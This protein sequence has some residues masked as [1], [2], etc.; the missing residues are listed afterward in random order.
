MAVLVGHR[1]TVSCIAFSPGGEKIATGSVD[2]TVR[3]W[4]VA[5]SW[6]AAVVEGHVEL[7][8][9]LTFSL[10]GS[11]VASGSYDN[12]ARTWN[13]ASGRE[14]AVMRGHSDALRALAFSS[15]GSKIASG[16]DDK[17]LRIWNT[18]RGLE[19]AVMRG[20]LDSVS[21]LAF[22]LDGSRIVSGSV[23]KTVRIWSTGDGRIVAV[24]EEYPMLGGLA[25]SPDGSKIVIGSWNKTVQ[26]IDAKTGQHIA[27]TSI[28]NPALH[29][30]FS[31]CNTQVQI[32]HQVLWEYMSNTLPV[33]L[34]SHLI[35]SYEVDEQRWLVNGG[36]NHGSSAS[37]I[38][39]I[40]DAFQTFNYIIASHN[41]LI[42]I[43]TDRGPGCLII[44]DISSI[45]P[46]T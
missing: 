16:S 41:S 25:I 23:D 21:C 3:I 20:H 32:N 4:N 5:N 9:C 34:P 1:D 28:G 30:S 19:M 39:R 29:L 2:S 22:S 17:T 42:A 14:V 18:A 31:S 33:S 10:D 37:R 44:L 8:T 11:Q 36:L 38:C 15:D 35:A 12:T 43:G 40:P 24:L 46:L 6:E 26:V 45:V 7:V 27:Q 13:V